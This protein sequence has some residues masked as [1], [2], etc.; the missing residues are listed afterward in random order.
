M[1]AM[2]TPKK[3]RRG[4]PPKHDKPDDEPRSGKT[5]NVTF[6][7]SVFALVEKYI[8]NLEYHPQGI[9]SEVIEKAVVYYLA[10]KGWTADK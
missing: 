6:S 2:G 10:S 1:L 3:I 5:V 9:R 8:E 4:R 7:P